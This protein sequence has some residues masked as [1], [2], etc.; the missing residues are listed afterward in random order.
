MPR[1][2]N[3]RSPKTSYI[4]LMSNFIRKTI[5]L[6]PMFTDNQQYFSFYS[7]HPFH[8]RIITISLY[9]YN[10]ALSANVLGWNKIG[11]YINKQINQQ[12]THT[13]KHLIKESLSLLVRTTAG[14]RKEC[15]GQFIT[16]FANILYNGGGH[17]KLRNARL[18]AERLHSHSEVRP[19]GSSCTCGR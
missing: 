19:P 8:I 5:G 17:I 1:W 9:C 13:R 3:V 10:T 2:A 6:K 18:S 12:S 11:K 7:S 16:F 4:F 15:S 14:T